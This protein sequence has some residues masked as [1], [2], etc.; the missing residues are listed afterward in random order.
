MPKILISLSAGTS[1]F[2]KD[3]RVV[4]KVANHHWFTGTVK[5]A[6]VKLHV[7]FDDG[8]HAILE[9]PDFK[10]VKPLL[11]KKTSKKPLN[12]RE[13]QELYSKKAIEAKKAGKVSSPIRVL[14]P[15]PE[16]STPQRKEIQLGYWKSK[17]SERSEL[18]WPTPGRVPSGFVADWE[19]M[20]EG[21]RGRRFRGHSTCRLCSKPNGSEEFS[22]R[23]KT[24]ITY[25]WPSGYLHYI[26]KHRVSPSAD[27]VQLLQLYKAENPKKF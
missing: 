23:S 18:P 15:E 4:V 10:R 16:E 22:Y 6:G 20:E 24:G 7:D 8:D 1:G 12:N 5:R 11:V 21:R 13:A 17:P 26:K 2:K 25:N 3:D 27:A 19:I 9:E 14:K